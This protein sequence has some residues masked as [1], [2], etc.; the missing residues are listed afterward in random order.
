MNRILFTSNEIKK[1]LFRKDDR[2]FHISR[3]LKLSVGDSFK[4]GVINE[5]VGMAKIEEL[6]KESLSFDFVLD[7][8]SEDKTVPIIPVIGACRPPVAKRLLK[9]LASMAIGKIIFVVSDL[10]DKSYLESRMWR[11]GEYR[12]SLIEGAS[13]GGIC[14]LPEVVLYNSLGHFLKKE[15]DNLTKSEK[16]VLDNRPAFF[17]SPGAEP[18]RKKDKLLRYMAIGPERGWSDR[19]RTLFNEAGFTPVCLSSAILRTEVATHCAVSLLMDRMD[20]IHF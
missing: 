4:A 11:E 17:S 9:D 20:L 2:Y 10:T 3:I 13:Q 6:T 8:P 19:E 15:V 14:S 12:K 16:I 18:G 7:P 1:P 5:S